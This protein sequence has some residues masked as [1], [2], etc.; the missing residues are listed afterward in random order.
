MTVTVSTNTDPNGTPRTTVLADGIPHVELHG[1]DHD[2]LRNAWSTAKSIFANR[3]RG[4]LRR[5]DG[6]AGLLHTVAE[7]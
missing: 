6:D 3:S 2:T 1:A 4:T 7:K 5:W